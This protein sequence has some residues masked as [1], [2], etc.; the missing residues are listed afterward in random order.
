MYQRALSVKHSDTDIHLPE[1]SLLQTRFISPILVN[2]FFFNG[3]KRSE[4]AFQLLNILAHE[5]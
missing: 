3:Q 2:K 4:L 1:Y 5:Q